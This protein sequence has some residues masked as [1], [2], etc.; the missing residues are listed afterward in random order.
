M[1]VLWPALWRTS[2]IVPV[3]KV[4]KTLKR[5][6]MTPTETRGKNQTS[7]AICKQTTHW[8]EWCCPLH[9]SSCPSSSGGIWHFYESSFFKRF[10]YYSTK[11]TQRRAHRDGNRFFLCFLSH[12]LPDRKATVCETGELCFWNVNKQYGS[13]TGDRSRSISFSH[14]IQHTPATSRNTQIMLPLVACIRN[15]QNLN[16]GIL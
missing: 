2:C 6:I 13:A 14:F 16:T 8:S 12:R 9:A 10:Q 1:S 11:Y 15:R 5:L 4:K 7:P 3:Q